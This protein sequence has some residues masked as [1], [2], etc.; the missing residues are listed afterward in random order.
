MTK[1]S[2]SRAW[3]ESRAVLARDGKLIGTVAL[4]LF[5]LPGLIVSLVA[6]KPQ[7]PEISHPGAWMIAGLVAGIIALIGQ[8]SVIRLAM[9]PHVSVGEAI[10]HAARRILPYLG[11]WLVWAAPLLLIGSALYASM[12]KDTAHPS[13]G[14]ALGLLVLTGIGVFLTVR[15]ALTS[16]VASAESV[17][18]IAILRRSW[19]LTRGNA[20]RLLG[21]FVIF[22]IGAMV[23]VIAV[24]SVAGLLAKMLF[25]DLS[26]LSVGGLLVSIVAQLLSAFIY[27]VLFVMLA[28]IYVQLA[29][30][31]QAEAGVPSSGT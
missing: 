23:L 30:T 20:W 22:A 9:A 2:I 10:A 16:G 6:P 21:F 13:A 3:D 12:G 7:S 28:R 15:F 5:V 8:I 27:V 26:P 18:P 17:G 14:A 25:G 1:L 29:G 19:E 4:A 24:G 11:S 31:A